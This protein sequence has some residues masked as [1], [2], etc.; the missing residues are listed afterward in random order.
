MYVPF[1][2]IRQ[3]HPPIENRFL[4]RKFYALTSLYT[5]AKSGIIWTQT[6]KT[7]KVHRWR[8]ELQNFPR[9]QALR[10]KEKNM[11][12]KR[13]SRSLLFPQLLQFQFQNAGHWLKTPMKNEWE[14]GMGKRQS[15][16]LRIS[17]ITIKVDEK[18]ADCYKKGKSTGAPSQDA[19]RKKNIWVSE[20]L[21][22]RL[23]TKA[24]PISVQNKWNI[25]CE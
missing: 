10:Y 8:L 16:Q 22:F 19:K 17:I 21:R 13:S 9:A 11:R 12:I 1:K 5:M 24:V 25:E 20:I 6:N 4:R 14:V 3:I 2:R 7:R 18:E 15:Q 23:N